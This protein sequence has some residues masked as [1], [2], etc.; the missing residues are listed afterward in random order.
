MSFFAWSFRLA[1]GRGDRKRD[2]DLVKPE[3]VQALYNLPYGLE[4]KYQ[5]LD[6]YFPKGT[7]EKLPVIVNIHG[8]GYLYGTKEVYLH[9][10]MSLAQHGFAVVNFNYTLAPKKKF[11]NQLCEINMVMEWIREHKDSYPFDIN[12]MFIVGDS[13][14][15]QLTSHYAAIY[16]N[17]EF[18]ALFPFV[19]PKECKIKA[20]ALNC[21]L[22]NL[23]GMSKAGVPAREKDGLRKDYLGN[24]P[25]EDPR[26]QV[27]AAI[28]EQFPPAYV[29]TSTFDFLKPSA[30]PMYEYLRSKGVEA[31]YHLYG[32]EETEYMGHVFHCNMNL[33][34]AH[35]CNADECRFFK[36]H[37]D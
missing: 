19:T 6:V 21:G 2:K 36:Q 23:T 34:E 37:I 8:G 20:V 33:K 17:P 3:N 27:V 30:E 32:T 22:Y 16:S 12:N 24:I 31:E 7:T 28:T 35:I 5:L 18:E 11:P 15:A 13:A 25:D 10:C 9:Y 14:G 4:G 29:M 26:L 1:A